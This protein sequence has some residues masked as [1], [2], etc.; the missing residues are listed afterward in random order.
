M[1]MVTCAH[2][3]QLVRNVNAIRHKPGRLLDQS[4]FRSNATG[5]RRHSELAHVGHYL[6]HVTLPFELQDAFEIPATRHPWMFMEEEPPLASL[7]L[8]DVGAELDVPF[9]LLQLLLEFLCPHL[10]VPVH[11]LVDLLQL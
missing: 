7:V 8:V 6:S 4:K 11:E 10:V 3:M 9:G 5:P 1:I 2:F